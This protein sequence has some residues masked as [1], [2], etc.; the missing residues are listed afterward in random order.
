MLGST[1]KVERGNN[2]DKK[3]KTAT[4]KTDKEVLSSF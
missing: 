2:T 1:L 4:K 3:M